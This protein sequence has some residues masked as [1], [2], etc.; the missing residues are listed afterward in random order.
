LQAS[1]GSEETI[2]EPDRWSI[3]VGWSPPGITI[4]LENPFKS[5]VLILVHDD[6]GFQPQSPQVGLAYLTAFDEVM[7]EMSVDWLKHYSRCQHHRMS[8]LMS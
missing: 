8:V 7:A 5:L 6:A 4:I 1:W 2:T 3:D